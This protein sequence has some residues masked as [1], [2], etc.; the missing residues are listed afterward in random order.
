MVSATTHPINSFNFRISL[1]NSLRSWENYI[2]ITKCINDVLVPG[3]FRGEIGTVS[4]QEFWRPVV[5]FVVLFVC[6]FFTFLFVFVF[7]F[8]FCS[9]FTFRFVVFFLF[10]FQ[11]LFL[12]YFFICYPSDTAKL[13][14]DLTRKPNIE[15]S[16]HTLQTGLW[17]ISITNHVH[18]RLMSNYTKRSYCSMWRILVWLAEISIA[19][20]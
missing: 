3:Y 11:L 19:Y 2:Q 13:V 16:Y 6:L 8:C 1:F 9:F 10:P 20:S 18:S 14:E 7:V 5:L 15:Y 4:K 12:F 17:K